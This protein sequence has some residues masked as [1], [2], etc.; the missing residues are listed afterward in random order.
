TVILVTH[1]PKYAEQGTRKI[2][3]RDG[4]IVDDSA[5]NSMQTNAGVLEHGERSTKGIS[6]LDL[7]KVG[8]REGLFVHKMR[9]ALTMLGIIIGV[10]GVIAMSSFSLGSKQ[11]QADQIRALGANMVRIVDNR[12]EGE[13]LADTRVGGSQGL[14]ISDMHLIKETIPGVRMAAGARGIKL[15]IVTDAEFISR[16]MGVTIGY[17]VVNNLEI[18]KGRFFDKTDFD[19]N[20]RVIV[21]GHS[22]A[23]KLGGFSPVGQFLLMGGVP[24]R[25]VGTMVNRSI[26]MKGLEASGIADANYDILMPI[27]TLLARTRQIEMRSE[28]D[29]IYIQLESEDMLFESGAALRRLLAMTHNGVTDF[30]LVIPLDLLRQKQQAQRL[31][32]VLTICISSIALLV[33][34]IGIMN[35]MLASVIERIREIG[36]RRTVGATRRDIKL[37]FLSE[38]VIIS[39]AGGVVGILVAFI[40]VA[41]TCVA[42][43]LPMVVS[44]FMVFLAVA[45]STLT[46]LVFGFYPAS[47]AATKDPVEALR[48]E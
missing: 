7:L 18:D 12:L 23:R 43:D 37:Q 27:Q 39:I 28:L 47:Q 31:L 30:R 4:G 6:F 33:G 22:I 11:K 46:G 13:K 15:N 41:V 9:T 42:I 3:L 29:E 26:D 17:P 25:I 32:D 21:V 2:I 44:S 48:Y 35:I 38:S 20:A 24:Y 14:S 16:I 1:D 36:I 19:N 45:A 40:G 8:L 34:G 10:A 5:V